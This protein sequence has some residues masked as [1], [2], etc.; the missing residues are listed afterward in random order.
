MCLCLLLQSPVLISPSMWVIHL[1]TGLMS[2]STW[3]I[4]LSMW[5]IHLFTG[6][7]HLSTWL[8]HLSTWLI[9]LSTWLSSEVYSSRCALL[10]TSV[11]QDLF[12]SGWIHS[13]KIICV[14]ALRSVSW[15]GKCSIICYCWWHLK[16]VA[17][18]STGLGLL[19]QRQHWVAGDPVCTDHQADIWFESWVIIALL[20]LRQTSAAKWLRC[21][22]HCE[23]S[24]VQ[25]L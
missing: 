25:L 3:L 12:G 6:L 7:I 5:L 16:I 18:I 9:H 21:C 2:L 22:V 13:L 14:H 17:L 10:V 19:N 24:G 15:I 1:S 11:D 4:H 8:I 23:T 20:K